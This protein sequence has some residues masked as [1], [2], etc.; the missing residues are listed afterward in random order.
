MINLDGPEHTWQRRA[1]QQAFTRKRVES[2]EATIRA[3]ANEL[4]DE[5]IDDGGCDLM[6]DFAMRLTLR[7]VGTMVGLPPDMLPGF[8]AWIVETFSLLAPIDLEPEDVT[9]PDEEIV[10]V[11]ERV[12]RA[13]LVYVDMLEER[14]AN[15]GDDLASA[16]LAL[17]DDDGNPTFTGDQVLTHMVSITAAGTDT[18]A[19]LIVNMVRYFTENPDQL[20]VVLDDPRLW[21]NAV[22]EGLRRSGIATQLFRITTRES[23]VAGVTIPPRSN[24][25][26]CLA[27]ANA[28]S[29]KFPD[30]LRFD[31]RR[32][33]AADHL[34]LGRG[35]HFCLGAPLVPPE[36][37]IALQVLYHRLPDLQADLDQPL[38][39][40]RSISLRGI[41][42]QRATWS[43]A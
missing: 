9:L 22:L 15:P 3:I 7:V 38:E 43:V 19:N 11:Y 24:V 35:R 36:S 12:Y 41:V 21:D 33:N 30:P 20:Q 26:A 5:L 13:Y 16:M 8:Q 10:G 37:R 17:T 1:V 32:V 25:C 42:S 4:I 29:A 18:T 23:K 28:D 40:V 6:R 27:A 39:F 14:R 2:T 34:G 31:V